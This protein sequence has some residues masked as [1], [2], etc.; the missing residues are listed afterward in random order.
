MQP[1]RLHLLA[2]A[3]E[4]RRQPAPGVVGLDVRVDLLLVGDHDREQEPGQVAAFGRVVPAGTDRVFRH[5]NVGP[6]H[7]PG[8]A[9]DERV[10]PKHHRAMRQGLCVA[11]FDRHAILVDELGAAC[12]RV[13]HRH[14]DERGVPPALPIRDQRFRDVLRREVG[15]QERIV[16]DLLPCPERLGL[17]AEIP[18]IH[19]QRVAAAAVVL[20][21]HDEPLKPGL[22]AW[23]RL[24]DELGRRRLR[25]EAEHERHHRLALLRVERELRHAVAL[26]VALVF[27][28][29]VVVAPGLAQL[30]PQEAFA[31][32]GEQFLEEEAG[33]GIDR[34]GRD[35]PV[36][37]RGVS[38]VGGE[39]PLA[40]AGCG[41]RRG[42]VV[43]GAMVAASVM[44]SMAVFELVHHEVCGLLE[45][46]LRR[47]LTTPV[48]QS[49]SRGLAV[50][51]AGDVVARIAGE[52]GERLLADVVEQHGV[53]VRR[54]HAEQHPLVAL[55]ICL[56]GAQ[57]VA[58]HFIGTH[59]SEAVFQIHDGEF[60]RRLPLVGRER[61]GRRDVGGL[62]VFGGSEQIGDGV[63]SRIADRAV[64]ERDGLEQHV[65]HDRARMVAGRLTEPA[66]EPGL[67]G[68]MRRDLRADSG[69]IR[70]MRALGLGEVAVLVARQTAADL[71]HLLAAFHVGLGRDALVG[72][73]VVEGGARAHEI[74]DHRANLDWLVPLRLFQ[75]LARQML[76][77]AEEPRHLRRRTEV[78]GIPQ[79]RIE[80]VE[81]DL[82]GH[83]PQRRPDL[84]E[85][86][87]RLG[88]LEQRG[89]LMR[90]SRQFGLAT[91]GGVAID[92]I[93]QPFAGL[94]AVGARP[95]VFD[96]PLD[97]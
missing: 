15:R 24:V 58:E 74:V 71:H 83:V 1:A 43:A 77:Q 7:R 25:H 37:R 23:R 85:A 20:F 73:H 13:E 5:H 93:P 92:G 4:R 66:V 16:G 55:D 48:G 19:A 61:I 3:H 32:V 18:A 49:S 68:G 44:A 54:I 70:A 10:V 33:V 9:V 30:L 14:A 11:L 59:R 63:G 56:I 81:A 34:F 2:L 57:P 35:V 6:A 82:A 80:P 17:I 87:G 46:D 65:R 64:G 72:R 76:P 94:R 79:P 12:F 51:E 97:R 84:G 86:A 27:R 39:W 62:P 36:R 50:F 31:F 52:L 38:Q 96:P 95:H 67:A 69:E 41:G 40:G 89:Q 75:P 90:T 45:G 8:F 78:L 28:L 22:F 21:C 88:L 42:P 26:V 91:G 60:F 47:F 53:F 29:L